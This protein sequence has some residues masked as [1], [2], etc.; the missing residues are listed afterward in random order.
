MTDSSLTR[1]ELDN[2]RKR[3][4]N[5]RISNLLLLI[6]R[7]IFLSSLA[8]GASY[9]V[10]SSASMIRSSSEIEIEGNQKLSKQEVRSWLKITYPQML[11]SLPIAQLSK[12]LRDEPPLESAKITREI[13]PPKLTIVVKERKPVA[14]ANTGKEQGFLDAGGTWINKG[15]YPKDSDIGHNISL[16]VKGFNDRY[17]SDWSKLYRHLPNSLVRIKSI[18]WANPDNLILQTELGDVHIGAYNDK[19]FVTKILVLN[20]M[21]NL[22]SRLPSERIAYIDLSNPQKPT[23]QVIPEAK[24]PEKLP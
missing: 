23:V 15:F 17:R 3:K 14:I 9:F 12:I 2:T 4:K 5:Q 22:T 7:L 6:W 24:D 11:W 8:V 13:L 20:K 18:D 1:T 21:K 19:D 16:T 10:N